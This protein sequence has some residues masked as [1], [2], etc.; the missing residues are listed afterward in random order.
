MRSRNI[1]LYNR[2]NYITVSF[3]KI[4]TEIRDVVIKIDND[5]IFNHFKSIGIAQDS[6]LEFFYQEI[7]DLLK[8]IDGYNSK[9]SQ[10]NLGNEIKKKLEDQNYILNENVIF[11]DKI[12]NLLFFASDNSSPL[13]FQKWEHKEFKFITFTLSRELRITLLKNII[14][15]QF[16]L[17]EKSILPSVKEF[18]EIKNSKKKNLPVNFRIEK[19][20]IPDTSLIPYRGTSFNRINNPSPSLFIWNIDRIFLYELLNTKLQRLEIFY[21]ELHKGSSA[22]TPYK[23]PLDKEFRNDPNNLLYIRDSNP[24]KIFYQPGEDLYLTHG[25]MNLIEYIAPFIPKEYFEN[26]SLS[27]TYFSIFLYGSASL[28]KAYLFRTNDCSDNNKFKPLLLLFSS[29]ETLTFMGKMKIIE[30]IEQNR[31]EDIVS[32]CTLSNFWLNLLTIVPEVSAIFL[33]QNNINNIPQDLILKLTLNTG[34]STSLCIAKD[35]TNNIKYSITDDYVAFF[36]DIFVYSITISNYK[37]DYNSKAAAVNSF[38]TIMGVAIATNSIIDPIAR[39]IM[40]YV[41]DNF[42]ENTDIFLTGVSDYLNLA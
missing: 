23:L 8:N 3:G 9:L 19:T 4:E 15:K 32:I 20:I 7:N 12:N 33:V 22:L 38:A 42:K 40:S 25:I 14:K 2:D 24:G 37:L 16:N 35:Y 30:N 27:K 36:V 26:Y 6:K 17:G 11:N 5:P 29:L 34:V 39:I 1:F 21:V 31:E 10:S 13:L 28:A 18:F 41:P